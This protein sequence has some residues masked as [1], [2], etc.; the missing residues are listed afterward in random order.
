MWLGRWEVEYRFV[1]L[2]FSAHE[3]DGDVGQR[4]RQWAMD[5]YLLPLCRLPEAGA[6]R[7]APLLQECT[8]G[9]GPFP[10]PRIVSVAE[11]MSVK[12]QKGRVAA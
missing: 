9:C 5:A 3:E 4:L 12:V 10:M 1:R 11:L 2:P 8:I 6:E 7:A